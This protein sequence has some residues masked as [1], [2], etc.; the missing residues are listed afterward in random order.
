MS[1]LMPGRGNVGSAQRGAPVSP[2]AGETYVLPRPLRR[3][4]RF[5]RRLIAGEVD[6]PRHAFAVMTASLLTAT[7]A[8]GSVLGGHVPAIVQTVASGTGFAI[9]EVAISGNE[10]T[11]EIDVMGALGLDGWTALPGFS[12]ADARVRVAGL[13]WVESATVRKIYPATLQIKL[14]ERRPFALWQD[15]ADIKVIER[16]GKVIAPYTNAKFA[17]LPLVVGEGAEKRADMFIAGMARFPAIASRVK[18]YVRVAD[19]RW[20]LRLDN[21]VTVKLPEKAE[22][23]AVQALAGLQ[24]RTGVLDKDIV[25]IDMRIEDRLTVQLS[26]GAARERTERM[27]QIVKEE[28][29]RGRRT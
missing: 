17:S 6:M 25:A 11:S 24:E 1:A 12:P 18:G 14:S 4:V 7:A 16:D 3:P 13:P 29:K 5:A 2:H 23:A 8:Y 19:R 28:I 15:G 22:L 9:T 26:E 20:D 27:E 10:E 21:G